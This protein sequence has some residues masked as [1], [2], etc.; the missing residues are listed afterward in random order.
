MRI[1][2]YSPS[3]EYPAAHRCHSSVGASAICCG[4]LHYYSNGIAKIEPRRQI[5]DIPIFIESYIEK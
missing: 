3:P 1:S 2:F 5:G 4:E